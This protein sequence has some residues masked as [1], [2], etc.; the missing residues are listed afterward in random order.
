MME[1]VDIFGD[2][3]PLSEVNPKEKRNIKENFRVRYG[4]DFSHRCGDCKHIICII[5]RGRRYY[6]CRLIGISH[7]TATDIYLK[8]ISC[9]QWA[10][11]RK[12]E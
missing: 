9:R 11:R 3:I 6:K 4:L 5:N 10:E 7:S 12:E 1:Q 8:D 2:N